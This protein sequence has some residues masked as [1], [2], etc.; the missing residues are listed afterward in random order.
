[1]QMLTRFIMMK[2]AHMNK[3]AEEQAPE[4]EGMTEY[5]LDMDRDGIV[6]IM[7]LRLSFSCLFTVNIH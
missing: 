1:M 4:E 3:L 5:Y 2:E 7:Y 6:C